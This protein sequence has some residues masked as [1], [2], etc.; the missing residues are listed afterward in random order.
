M[1]A[2]VWKKIVK[3]LRRF[4]RGGVIGGFKITLVRWNDVCKP[5]KFEGIGFH[6][7]Q[8]FKVVLLDKCKTI[9]TLKRLWGLERYFIC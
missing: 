3:I 7:L 6:D 5:K 1:I 2:N 4:L 9:A 8:L